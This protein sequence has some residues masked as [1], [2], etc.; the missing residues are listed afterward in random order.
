MAIWT[1]SDIRDK[2][3]KVTGRLTSGEISNS[4]LDE[5]INKFYQYT[6]PA[7]LKLEKKHT[8]YE[9]L[10]SANQKWYAFPNEEYTNVEPIA[11]IDGHSLIWFQNPDTFDNNNPKQVIR[12][13]PWTGDGVT[14]VF[15]TGVTQFPIMP[16]TTVVTDDIETFQ[17]LN[18]DWT[19]SDVF[20]TGDQG[21]TLTLNYSTGA[22]SVSFASPPLNGQQIALSYVQF[23]AG[24]P[25]SVLLYNNQFEF[26][27][28]PDTAYR[29]KVK[30]YSI[31]SPFVEPEDRPE[32][33][34][35]GPCIAYGASRDI[36]SDFGEI[37][38]YQEVTM[39]YKEQLAYVLKRTHQNLLNTRAM[40]SF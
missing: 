29:F 12:S 31:V 16:S 7:E 1:L 26:A 40:P 6:F 20:I 14:S 19:T 30:A 3:R 4:R 15:N 39:L 8:F 38:A 25:Q 32:L 24:R 23:K 22:I 27:P 34:Q 11:T 36:H 33:D 35:W 10:T 5:Y 9:F 37:E 13:F 18:Q 21:G 17:D 28:I 2:V